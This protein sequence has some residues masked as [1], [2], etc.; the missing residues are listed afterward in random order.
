MLEKA[1]P[2]PTLPSLFDNGAGLL[3][4]KRKT[5][6]CLLRFLFSITGHCPLASRHLPHLLNLFIP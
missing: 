1:M 3:P 4:S 6:I 2:L 5:R